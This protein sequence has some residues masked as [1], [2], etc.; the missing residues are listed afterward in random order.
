M[1]NNNEPKMVIVVR[2]D[3]SMGKGKLAAQVAH[4]AM[5][6]LFRAHDRG[7]RS[8][9][10]C[11]KDKAEQQWITER[12]KKV[13]VSVDSEA[14]LREL[15]AAGRNVSIEVNEIVDAGLTEFNGI[16]TLTCAAFGPDLPSRLDPLTGN[17]SLL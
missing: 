8:F 13:V 16:P 1:E 4:A 10:F 12:F 9:I 14:E 15:I 17:L 3:I 5:K 11:A 7:S 2:K 6:F